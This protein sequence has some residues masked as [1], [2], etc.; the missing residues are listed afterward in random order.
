MIWYLITF[1]AGWYVRELYAVRKINNMLKE[2]DLEEKAELKPDEL[3]VK[4]EKHNDKFYLYA[5]SD[6][7]FIAQGC[8]KAEVAEILKK[9]FSTVTIVADPNNVKE[10]DFK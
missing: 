2:M 5:E 1:A 7:R 4:I 3:R 6:D 8:T 9:H 10:V